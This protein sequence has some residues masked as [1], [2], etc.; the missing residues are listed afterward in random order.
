MDGGCY[1]GKIRYEVTGQPKLKAQCHCRECQYI[2]GGAPSL[3]M[4]IPKDSFRY[5][6]GTPK[7]FTRDDLKEAV[8]REFCADCGTHLLAHRPGMDGFSLK[9]GTLDDPAEFDMAQ[10][11]IFTVDKQPFH[12]IPDN[13]PV[14][15]KRPETKS[16]S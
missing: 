3:F 12:H 2:S 15:D 10:L 9:I 16:G 4:F 13:I 8:T 11:A 7:Q 5:T 14:F 6:S 1:C